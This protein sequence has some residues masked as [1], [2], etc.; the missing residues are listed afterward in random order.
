MIIMVYSAFNAASIDEALG[1]PE[2]SYWFVRRA[3]WPVLE[4]SGIVVP[5]TDPPREV[6]TI[7][8]SANARGETCVFLSFEPPH[9]TTLGLKCRTIPVFAWE[10][11]TMPDEV[12]DD[13][14]RND[15]RTVLAATGSAITHSSFSAGVIRRSMG[16]DYPV[17]SIPAPVYDANA[18]FA[19]AA[20]PYQPTTDLT[21]GAMVIDSS[22]VDLELFSVHRAYADGIEALRALAK[23]LAEARP[24]TA[25]RVAGVVYTVVFNPIDGRKNFNDILGGFLWAFRDREDA[26]LILK[27]TYY[28]AVRGLLPVLSDLAKFGRYRCRVVLIHGMLSDEE[29]RAL[30]R[31]TSYAVNASTNEG[32][33]LPLMEFMSA[34]RPAVAP[35]HTALLD[36]ISPANSFVVRSTERLAPWPHDSRQAERA[37]RHTVSVADIIRAYRE[38]YRVARDDPARY[39]AMSRAA[40][41]SLRA[42]CATTLV[43]QRLAEALS[44]SV[45]PGPLPPGL[46][47]TPPDKA[48]RAAV[49]MEE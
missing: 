13:E 45:E 29:Y 16:A 33:C 41:E 1:A 17:W 11:D 22:Q 8:A 39:A 3:F 35:A 44:A 20:R 25:L 2:Y 40:T 21:F 18:P 47:A 12:W 23:F 49:L 34:G 42:F 27:I 15:W 4:R 9:K 43:E 24:R 37:T 46:A 26:M 5:V 48:S 10:F 30:V 36:Y 14:P 6:D 32:Q 38:S 31:V 19:A 7:R 28:D